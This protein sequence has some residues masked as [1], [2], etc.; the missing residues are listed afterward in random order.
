MRAAG[1][2]ACPWVASP[3]LHYPSQSWAWGKVWAF[4]G[5]AVFPMSGFSNVSLRT[6][7]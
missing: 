2:S 1:K 7:D 3:P 6:F 4:G 5:A